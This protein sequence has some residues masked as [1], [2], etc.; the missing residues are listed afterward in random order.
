MSKSQRIDLVIADD[1]PAVLS[2]LRTVFADSEY[3]IA[4]EAATGEDALSLTRKHKPDVLLLDVRL[5]DSGDQTLHYLSPQ[6]FE[7]QHEQQLA[8]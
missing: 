7:A 1:H 6:P 8:L 4:A 2:G 3:R 5:P